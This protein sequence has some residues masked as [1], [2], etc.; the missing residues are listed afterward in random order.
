MRHD[1]RL[2]GR[3]AVPLAHYLGALGVLRLVAEQADPEAR[4]CWERDTFILQTRLDRNEVETF[5]LED[6]EPTP[7]VAPWNGG[8]GFYSRDNTSAIDTITTASASRLAPYQRAIAAARSVL[9][10]LGIVEKPTDGKTQ[11]LTACRNRFPEVALPWLDA[12]FALTTDGPKYPPLLGTGGNDGRLE[13]SNNHMQRLLDLFDAETG[14]SRPAT[15]GLLRDALFGEACADLG[16]GAIG[17]FLPRSAGGPNA[18]SHFDA[19][20]LFNPWDFV[21]MLEGAVLFASATS[22]RLEHEPGGALA[23]PFAVRPASVGYGSAAPP[24]EETSNSRHEMWLPL[25]GAPAALPELKALLA[26][27]RGRVAGRTAANGVDFARAISTLGVDRGI[28]AFQRYGF[29]VRNGLAYFATPLTR[30]EVRERPAV[31]LLDNIDS[32][33]SSLRRAVTSDGA[34]ASVRRA[35]RQLEQAIVAFCQR[36]DALRSQDVLIAL[37]ETE[38]AI[39]NSLRWTKDVGLRPLPMLDAQWVSH[40][41]DDSAEWRLALALGALTATFRPRKAEESPREM[42]LRCHLEPVAVTRA[43][44]RTTVTW[45]AHDTRDVV[46]GRS[47]SAAE[48]LIAVLERRL[49]LFAQQGDVP[50]DGKRGPERPRSYRDRARHFAR[51]DD[52]AAFIE[53][54]VDDT[55]L[56]RLV[57]A[58]SLLDLDGKPAPRSEQETPPTEPVEAAYGLFKLCFA[59][60]PLQRAASI[61]EIDVPVAPQ[62]LRLA[63]AGRGGQAV[64]VAARRL[65]GCGLPPATAHVDPGQIRAPRIA[66]AVLF[67]LGNKTLKTIAKTVLRPPE[68]GGSNWVDS[69]DR[70]STAAQAAR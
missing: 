28:S 27:G 7:L 44:K 10:R 22:R 43:G 46:W 61:G 16:G 6:Y 34:P 63:A 29:Q 66:A 33:L 13:F 2:E 20:A 57:A 54:R 49:H 8:S 26:E 9:T 42:P 48:R 25:W 67:P 50:A 18:R 19:N 35:H 65:R 37:A 1:H 36:D 24:D 11:L 60:M 59:G 64:E 3:R 30:L 4:G 38:L 15:A 56:L 51:A 14:A 55:R 52:V 12:A 39:A 69:S 17:Q 41:D 58:S 53:Q 31:R 45:L 70:S 32:L 23:F 47:P 40:C 62:I 21:L 5:F 68:P